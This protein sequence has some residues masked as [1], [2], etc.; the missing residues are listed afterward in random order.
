[1]LTESVRFWVSSH[2]PA[3]HDDTGEPA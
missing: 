1:M 3:V 2:A